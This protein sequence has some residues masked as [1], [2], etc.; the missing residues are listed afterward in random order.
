MTTDAAGE[1]AAASTYGSVGFAVDGAVDTPPPGGDLGNLQV[2]V[3]GSYQSESGCP[4]DW[5]P[6]CTATQLAYQGNGLY[7]GTFTVPAGDWEYKIAIGGSWNENYGA[8]GV[9]G[10]DNITFS[11]TDTTDVTFVYDEVSH[12]MTSSAQGPLLTLPGDYQSKVGCAGDWDPSCLATV[13]AGRRR[14]RHGDVHHER[15]PGRQLAGQGGR[16]PVV[17]RELRR[18]RRAR[19]REHRLQ[20]AAAA[21]RSRSATTRRR[22]C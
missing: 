7:A 3:P 5:D 17:G 4:G 1:H 8:G 10:G 13:A 14:R 20:L 16:R 19:R 11:L 21:S 6:A 12:Q 9:P 15:H 18:G 22:T 2:T